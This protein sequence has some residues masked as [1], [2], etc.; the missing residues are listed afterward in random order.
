MSGSIKGMIVC[1]E[2][3]LHYD[4][5][6]SRQR[7]VCNAVIDYF[8]E[9]PYQ[10]GVMSGEEADIAAEALQDIAINSI[11]FEISKVELIDGYFYPIIV[12]DF[13]SGSDMFVMQYRARDNRFVSHTRSHTPDE[14]SFIGEPMT[15]ERLFG[16]VEQ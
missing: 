5:D 13:P 1:G 8:T 16:K 7:A 14:M 4:L 3:K 15:E 12:R 6:E 11:K 9:H 2:Y 10:P